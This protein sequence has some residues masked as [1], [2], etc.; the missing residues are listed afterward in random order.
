[1]AVGQFFYGGRIRHRAVQLDT[2]HMV[3]QRVERGGVGGAFEKAVEGVLGV[4]LAPV[5]FS[6]VHHRAGIFDQR[7]QHGQALLGRG[8]GHLGGAEPGDVGGGIRVHRRRR[9]SCRSPGLR[10]NDF[11]RGLRGQGLQGVLRGGALLH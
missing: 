6:S 10:H 3:V 5:G 1:M 2:P 11:G 7:A 4:P 9:Q 8:R